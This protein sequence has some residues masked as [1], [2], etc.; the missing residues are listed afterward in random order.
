MNM[1]VVGVLKLGKGVELKLWE[2]KNHRIGTLRSG[3]RKRMNCRTKEFSLHRKTNQT[4]MHNQG[5]Q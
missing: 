3:L 4:V 1:I 5:C 2:D